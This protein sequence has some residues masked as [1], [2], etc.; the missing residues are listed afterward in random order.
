M[1]GARRAFKV[2]DRRTA[3]RGSGGDAVLNGWLS[4]GWIARDGAFLRFEVGIILHFLAWSLLDP[5][6]PF[7]V[8]ELGG[9]PAMVGIV[10]GV[11]S[12]APLVLA[13]AA[14]M[15][16]DRWG[17]RL[18]L[19][20]G[21]IGAVGAFLTYFLAGSVGGV[22]LGQALFGTANLLKVISAQS[23]IA[24]TS[25][26]E[27]LYAN[28]GRYSFALS[29]GTLVGP[30]MG[31]WLLEHGGAWLPL[32][33]GGFRA[34]F[35]A[36]LVCSALSAVLHV[37]TADVPG[38][39]TAAEQG[40][41]WRRMRLLAGDRRLVLLL[42]AS[43]LVWFAIAL[44][45]SYFPLHLEAAGL[46]H[47]AVGMVL[48]IYALANMLIRPALGA[49]V[50]RFGVPRLLLAG[51]VTAAVSVALVPLLK[52]F[53]SLA[54]IAALWGITHGLSMPA[55]MAA[56]TEHARQEDKGLI[57]SVRV[58]V[59]RFGE[60][61]SPLIFSAAAGG[62]GLTAP[63]WVSAVFLATGI[64][65]AWRLLWYER[66]GLP[67]GAPAAEAAGTVRR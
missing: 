22:V 4:N 25:A 63:F 35:V 13:V 48:S 67:D 66:H 9:T 6:I 43:L 23:W 28:F 42:G 7:Y 50:S 5:V 21:S 56:V 41:S 34:A 19:V 59:N 58:G 44:R 62:F 24:R 32:E 49:A 14:G 57:V 47:T 31:G 55:V 20:A 46:T 10:L 18:T 40:G 51:F 15:L 16:V 54:V 17:N 65:V 64:W 3:G 39:A 33:R 29:I 60:G 37:A 38:G 8:L 26:P 30:M 11:A 36:G 1:S 52:G 53:F 2:A 27:R 45:R 61:I 12:F